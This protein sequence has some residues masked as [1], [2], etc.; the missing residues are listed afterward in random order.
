MWKSN[1]QSAA[2]TVANWPLN[3]ISKLLITIFYSFLF[4]QFFP[5]MN[6]TIKTKNIYRNTWNFSA[7]DNLS[8]SPA[9]HKTQSHT[10]IK[11][12]FWCN[13]ALH[14]TALHWIAYYC[15]HST[16]Y[17][18]WQM[19]LKLLWINQ[20]V[21]QPEIWASYSCPYIFIVVAM[22]V[23]RRRRYD[24]LYLLICSCLAPRCGDQCIDQIDLV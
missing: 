15:I 18:V 11:Q 13:T 20:H 6:D 4:T 1:S 9:L 7:F 10:A 12:T 24:G 23:R 8:L 17:C 5:D 2:F 19:S 3:E 22:V 14:C 21:S 16:Y